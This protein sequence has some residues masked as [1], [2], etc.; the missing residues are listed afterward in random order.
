MTIKVALNGFGRIGRLTVRA[1]FE[2]PRDDLELVAINGSRSTELMAHLLKYD[3]VHGRFGFDVDYTD[4]ALIIDGKKIPVTLTRNPEELP[5]GDID[6]AMEC[7]GK[8]KDQEGASKYLKAG[9]KKVLISAPGTC[10][11]FTVVYG[12]NHDKVTAEHKIVS[13]ASCTTNC[14]APVAK[15]L[16]DVIGIESGFV[17]TV[18]AYTGDQNTVDGTH[19]DFRRARAAGVSIAPTTTGAAKAVGLVLPEMAGKLDGTSLRVPAPN[20]S[21]IDLT[22]VPSRKTTVEEIHDAMN[23]AASGAMNGVLRVESDPVVSIDLNHD[24]ASAVFDTSGTQVV[25]DNLVRVMA[26]YDNEWGFSVRMLDTASLL[27]SI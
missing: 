9:A 11:D 5:W 2:H 12:V 26:W 22:F 27:G 17:T 15:V 21:L 19:K 14:L 23:A 24:A 7:T 1:F 4:D 8:F 18:H 10:S 3:S 20:V 25:S 13:N 6:V 16:N